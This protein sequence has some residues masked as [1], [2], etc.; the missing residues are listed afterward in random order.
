MSNYNIVFTNSFKKAYKKLSP[1]VQKQVKV[2]I[3][4]LMIEPSIP[5]LRLKINY[6]WSSFL[7]AK[8][9]EISVTMNYRIILTFEE[10]RIVLLHTIGTHDILDKI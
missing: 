8:A 6:S 5:S 7:K 10:G 9:Y 1:E 3:E 2:K 4:Q